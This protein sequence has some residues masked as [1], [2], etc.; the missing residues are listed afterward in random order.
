MFVLLLC[1]MLLFLGGCGKKE[2]IQPE[3]EPPQQQQQEPEKEPEEES[4]KEK[5]PEPDLTGKAINTL[6]GLY[7][8]EETAQ[9]RPVA[10]MI[11]NAPKA[12]PQSGIASADVI[13]EALAEGGITRFTAVF[14]EMEQIEKIGPVRSARDYFTYF[15]L[16]NDAIYVHHGG[17]DGGYLAIKNRKVNNMNGMYD[18]DGFWRDPERYRQ[19]GMMEHSSYTNGERI[20]DLW[21]K[22]GYRLE[23]EKLPMFSFYDEDTQ[24]DTG[25]EASIVSLDY[26]YYQNSEFRYLP[27]KKTYERWQNGQP[28]IDDQTGE[29]V[30]TKNIIIQIVNGRVI[31]NEGRLDLDLVGQGKGYLVT[32]G[33]M[34]E[35]SWSKQSYSEP[36]KWTN[37]AGSD[38]KLN[39]G[40][41]WICVFPSD[42]EVIAE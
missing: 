18:D 36:T 6:T 11:N 10:V 5:E 4:E 23:M 40:K 31:D 1:S 17:S 27:E 16:D 14:R 9:R 26:S 15:A 37:S 13:Y 25:Q 2:E 19:P 32:D 24:P 33:K 3:E 28:Q 39:T 8:D 35:L 22:K 7:I 38:L 21:A 41:T 29:T 30:E 12:L 20:L 34:T 42:R